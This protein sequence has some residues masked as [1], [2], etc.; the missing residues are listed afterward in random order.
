M[1]VLEGWRRRR[2][3]RRAR[4]EAELERHKQDALKVVYAVAGEALE[5]GAATLETKWEEAP[6]GRFELYELWPKTPGACPV[7]IAVWEHQIELYLGEGHLHELW[8]KDPAERLEELRRCLTAVVAG[9]YEEKVED[10]GRKFVGT[11]HTP[12]GPETFAHTG[13]IDYGAPRRRTFRPYV[14]DDDAHGGS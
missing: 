12:D 1:R 11:F 8:Q 10:E 4:A 13:A 2:N 6:A 9:R 3:E 14:A 5:R 7:E